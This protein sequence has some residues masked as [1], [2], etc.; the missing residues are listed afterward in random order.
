[1]NKH[2]L[3]LAA[4]A[5]MSQPIH[6][7]FNDVEVYDNSKIIADL[8]PIPYVSNYTPGAISRKPKQPNTGFKIGSYNSRSK[9]KTK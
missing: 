6:A 4:I 5:S 3:T 8:E 2:K 1:M 9:N 7:Q